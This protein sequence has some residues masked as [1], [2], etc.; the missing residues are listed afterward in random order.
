MRRRAPTASSS[1]RLWSQ[2]R[3][4]LEPSATTRPS[5]SAPRRRSLDTHGARVTTGRFGKFGGRFV[6]EALIPALEQLDEVRLKA[7]MDPEFVGELERLH[8][9]HRPAEHHHRGAAV[10][11]A[12]RGSAG[13]PQARGP[14]PHR[15][16]QDQQRAR[17]G[18]ADQA[19]GQVARHRRDRRRTARRRH[20]N[21]GAARPRLHRLHGQGRHR[22]GSERRGCACSA[23][24]S[25]L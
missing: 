10:R 23:P 6:P 2:R 15:V 4:W 19:D 12:R 24:R 17:P 16:P 14:E 5:G 13:H 1:A 8:R 18:P 9:V 21:G 22:A 20:R 7:M 3:D 11:R 25:C